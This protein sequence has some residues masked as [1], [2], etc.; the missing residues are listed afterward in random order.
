[1]LFKIFEISFWPH[2]VP[3]RFNLREANNQITRLLCGVWFL[4]KNLSRGKETDA[5]QFYAKKPEQG[6]QVSLW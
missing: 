5:F 1:M 4:K 2:L 3:D 6:R